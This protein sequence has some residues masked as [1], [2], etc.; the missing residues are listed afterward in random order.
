[1]KIIDS[2]FELILII[3]HGLEKIEKWYIKKRQYLVWIFILNFML[4]VILL[5][6]KRAILV[7]ILF[8]LGMFFI[9]LDSII[10]WKHS[11]RRWL[12][13]GVIYNL[14]FSLILAS[15]VQGVIQYGIVNSLFI[16]VYLI[17][18]LFL[19]LISNSKVSLLVN[20]IVSG[21]ATTIFTIGTYLINMA[22]KN[23]PSSND[24]LIYFKTDERFEQAL[25]NGDTLAW[26][27]LRSGVLEIL[28]SIFI[29]LLPIIGIT[30][31]CIIMI[32][33]KEYWMEKNKISE[34]ET[35]IGQKDEQV[36]NVF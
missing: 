16:A 33:I 1:M 20:E 35:E 12:K 26:I 27:F 13:V 23:M 22:L 2:F 3:Q 21:A 14:I 29:S 25:E 11:V 10:G 19:S 7:E 28:E 6:R 34:P 24:Y 8:I 36:V 4:G 5:L 9:G 18:W 17:V 15:L 32:K 30:A 31:L